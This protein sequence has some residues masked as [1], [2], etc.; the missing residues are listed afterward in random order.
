MHPSNFPGVRRSLTYGVFLFSLG[1]G[2]V[3][4]GV[5]SDANILPEQA[6][7]QVIL[8]NNHP[9]LAEPNAPPLP[10]N[11]RQFGLIELVGL[12]TVAAMVF[13]LLAPLW[14]VMSSERQWLFLSVVFLQ[15]GV[16]GG[17]THRSS[18]LSRQVA[19]SRGTADRR[20]VF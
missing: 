16:V 9:Q 20:G 17:G 5:G 3:K 1:R 4:V 14:R 13:A 10:A 7:C 12:L 2:R 18:A 15:V 11:P 6:H 8:M 19:G